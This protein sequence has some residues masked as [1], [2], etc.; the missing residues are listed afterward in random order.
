MIFE[1]ISLQMTLKKK[2][3]SKIWVSKSKVQKTG[4]LL[5]KTEEAA[6]PLLFLNNE[7]PECFLHPDFCNS[8]FGPFF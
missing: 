5:S 8:Y 4:L 3:I 2:K 6:L 1:L 7:D